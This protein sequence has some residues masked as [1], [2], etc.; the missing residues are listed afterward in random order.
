MIR[1]IVERIGCRVVEPAHHGERSMCCGFGAAAAHFRVMDIMSSGCR[2]L[3]ELEGTGA[4]AAVIYCP[5]CLFILS[6]IREMAGARIPFYHPVELVE[7]AAGGRPDRRHDDRAWDMMAVISNH[8]VKYALFPSHR[9]GFQP[10]AI[11]P[12]IEPL[13][14]LPP[15]DRIRMKAL[16]TLH[17]SPVVQNRAMRAAISLGFEA[18]VGGYDLARKRRLGL[19]V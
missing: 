19:K 2:R 1:E 7:A 12:E 17:H 11:S 6:V 16:A 18:A 4:D 15:W 8:L 9:K 13:P 5:A 10:A 3:K 14:E